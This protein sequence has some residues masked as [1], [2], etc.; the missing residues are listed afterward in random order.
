MTSS[1]TKALV[2]V[3]ALAASQAASL[4]NSQTTPA[5]A[6][7]SKPICL[8]VPFAPGGSTDILL[9]AVAQDN[10]GKIKP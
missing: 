5:T 9:R 6:Y 8:V 4:C 10:P 2:V 1:I 7:P 3:V